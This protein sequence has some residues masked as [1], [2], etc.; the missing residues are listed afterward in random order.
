MHRKTEGA[1]MK[2]KIFLCIDFDGTIADKVGDNLILKDGAKQAL[3]RF[4]AA[5]CYILIDSSR[6]NPYRK[7]PG[8]VERSLNEMQKFLDSNEIPYDAINGI[9]FPAQA[10]PIAD[11][12]IADNNITMTNWK[13]VV[14]SIIGS[15]IAFED[16]KDQ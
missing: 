7:L 15:E 13:D 1:E 16:K 3:Q 14:T 11:F 4:K 9:S 2:N 6:A 12:Y 8:T 5:N 10:R